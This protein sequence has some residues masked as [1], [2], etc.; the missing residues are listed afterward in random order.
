MAE[1]SR[2]GLESLA[3]LPRFRGQGL[4]RELA[5]A[6][7]DMV[8]RKTISLSVCSVNLP[9]I[10]LYSRLGFRQTAVTNRWWRLEN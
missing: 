1:I 8:P 2:R 10:R 9:A 3:V 7:L 6:V 4:G 5:L